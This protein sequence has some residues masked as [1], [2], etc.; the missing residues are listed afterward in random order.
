MPRVMGM[1]WGV[2][3]QWVEAQNGVCV[4]HWRLIHNS[5]TWEGLPVTA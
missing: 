1:R 4:Q 5:I 2:K 3:L